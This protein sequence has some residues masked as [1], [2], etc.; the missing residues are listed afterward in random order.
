MSYDVRHWAEQVAFLARCSVVLNTSLASPKSGKS[1]K[2]RQVFAKYGSN[3]VRVGLMFVHLW[4]SICADERNCLWC[5]VRVQVVSD[6]TFFL[7]LVQGKVRVTTFK[8]VMANIRDEAK[9]SK[10]NQRSQ[11]SAE[12]TVSLSSSFVALVLYLTGDVCRSQP[13]GWFLLR[14]DAPLLD[15]ESVLVYFTETS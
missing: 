1:W 6:K 2:A 11:H 10:E 7:R 14:A 4:V 9:R 15:G 12:E 13:R 3:E 5:V 8:A